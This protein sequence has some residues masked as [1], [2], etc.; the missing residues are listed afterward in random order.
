MKTSHVTR[1]RALIKGFSLALLISL[2]F[3]IQ[4]ARADLPS[5]AAAAGDSITMGFAAD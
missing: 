3:G 4:S 5:N 2:L 1:T